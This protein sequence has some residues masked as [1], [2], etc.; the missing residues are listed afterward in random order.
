MSILTDIQGKIEVQGIVIF[1]D[2]KPVIPIEAGQYKS[3]DFN[4]E[5]VCFLRYNDETNFIPQKDGC[6]SMY[7]AID[8]YVLVC[9]Q[10]DNK[11]TQDSIQEC[12]ASQIDSI[13]GKITKITTNIETIRSEEKITKNYFTGVKIYFDYERLYAPTNCPELVC[14]C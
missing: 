2:N 13:S 1:R 10:L 9:L 4:Q 8:K 11:F 5:L 12:L 7:T 6:G 14:I 3:I